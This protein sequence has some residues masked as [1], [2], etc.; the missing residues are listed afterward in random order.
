M[1]AKWFRRNKVG[2][3]S[4]C[5]NLRKSSHLDNEAEN[6]R[7][8][9]NQNSRWEKSRSCRL[10][11][12]LSLCYYVITKLSAHDLITTASSDWSPWAFAFLFSDLLWIF[13]KNH[14]YIYI[15]IAEFPSISLIIII[16]N[17]YWYCYHLP[18]IIIL[19]YIINPS[20]G[21]YGNL[22]LSYSNKCSFFSKNFYF[23]KSLEIKY[24]A[25]ELCGL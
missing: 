4:N 6:K 5:W 12:S 13:L 14:Y 22:C 10:S 18:L 15:Y 19:N 3:S 11:L 9:A 1:F 7:A 20:S 8:E 24:L 2:S 21:N 17:Y 16:I 25:Q 23:Q